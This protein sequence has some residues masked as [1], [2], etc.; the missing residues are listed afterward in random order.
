MGSAVSEIATPPVT[1][2]FLEIFLPFNLEFIF[3]AALHLI[4]ADALF[5]SVV[6]D[7]DY[8]QQALK[9]LDEMSRRGNR[10]AEVRKVEL[11]HLERLCQELAVRS[12]Q[13][14]LQTLSLAGPERAEEMETNVSSPGRLEQS[15]GIQQSGTLAAPPAEESENS[16]P[17]AG[18]HA[19]SNIEFLDDIGISSDEF[20]SLVDQLD[21]YDIPSLL[22]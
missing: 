3:A 14:G 19:A 1:I 8:T 5:P 9:I 2:H 12:E 20:F 6:D 7:G 18:I 15:I 17:S 4:M 11:A 21:N 13:R 16:S 10:V 22:P